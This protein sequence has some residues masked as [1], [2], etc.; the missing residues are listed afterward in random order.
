MI[1]PRSPSEQELE[2]FVGLTEVDIA[3]L[4][5]WLM[6][7]EMLGGQLSAF[8][9]Q[10]LSAKPVEGG[11]KLRFGGDDVMPIRDGTG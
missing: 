7:E 11:E 8:R 1:A 10:N 3:R 4:V 2:S 9:Y 6:V 5:L